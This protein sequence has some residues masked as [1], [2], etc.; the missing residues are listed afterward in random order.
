MKLG[1]RRLS[2]QALRQPVRYIIRDEFT[3][4]IV[5]GS[6][7]GTLATP[8]PGTRK[9]ID[10][11]VALSIANGRCKASTV[12]ASGNP[13]LWYGS[14]SRKTGLAML[15]KMESAGNRLYVGFDSNQTG[16][17]D[18]N[19]G[20]CFHAAAGNV[21]Y[22]NSV[23]TNLGQFVLNTEYEIVVIL[24]G[25]GYFLAIKNGIFTDWTLLWVENAGTATPIYPSAIWRDSGSL[26]YVDSI[27]VTQL[28]SPWNS[29]YGIATQHLVGERTAG[30]TFS[31][32]AT[33]SIIEFTV[34]ALPST[35]QIEV[36]FRSPTVGTNGWRVTVDSSGNL[37]LDEIVATV[38][39]QRGTSAGVIANGDR[40]VIV[41]DGSTIKVYEGGTV[42]ITYG[43]AATNVG[44]TTC[45]LETLGT[46]GVVSEIVT[47]PRRLTGGANSVLDTFF[48]NNGVSL[49]MVWTGSSISAANPG[50]STV[51]ETW[52]DE[53]YGLTNK[54]VHS[55]AAEASR[56]TWFALKNIQANIL[57]LP[58]TLVVHDFANGGTGHIDHGSAE[59]FIR[60]IWT[61]LPNASIVM[62][63]FFSVTDHDVD[64]N[65]NH[66][67][68]QAAETMWQDICTTYGI[69][70]V[71]FH[72]SVSELV[73]NQG[74]HL[75]EY[76]A[77]TVHPSE[78]GYNLAATLLKNVLSQQFLTTKQ[79]NAFPAYIY[80]TA[81]DYERPSSVINGASETSR[82]GTWTENGTS[83]SSNEEG[84]TITYTVTGRSIG[85]RNSLNVYPNVDI[86]TGGAAYIENMFIS[87]NGFQFAYSR[88]TATAITFRVRAGGATVTIDE[89][90]II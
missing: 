65:V 39:T 69:P 61:T 63:G 3:T 82:T 46:G 83:I 57:G 37:D 14:H 52:L 35:D 10:T 18:I 1:R 62:M 25:S 16:L 31:H 40:I 49:D 6:I 56:N 27:R 74:H 20:I 48:R 34:S 21:M 72:A 28:G 66:A 59:A 85:I 50:F 47:W 36:W 38:V 12:A 26:R 88:L 64:D 5:A 53:V 51:M 54:V 60:R 75:N 84:A 77:D 86:S 24:R 78:T 79:F 87:P 15:A 90:W 11:G 23:T 29:E 30:D 80:E 44:V 89:V 13:G 70:Y 68:S 4:A 71:D 81:A 58:K 55:N 67:T 19:A 2:V 41:G 42:R 33:Y 32:V 22:D 76:L 8:G 7:E 45:E 17:P 73:N 43:S 9:V